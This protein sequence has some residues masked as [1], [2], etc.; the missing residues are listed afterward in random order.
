M[1]RSKRP[2]AQQGRVQDVGAVGGTDQH[3]PGAH[4]EAVHLDQQ[5]VQ[6]LFSFP[7]RD[8]LALPAPAERVDLVD[9]HDG[10]GKRSHL[11]EQVSHPGGSHPY[12]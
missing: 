8:P 7:T 5:L 9:E 6:G 11:G 4:L 1:W 12:Q 3:H 10:G 2:G